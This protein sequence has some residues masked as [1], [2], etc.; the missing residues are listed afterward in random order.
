[1]ILWRGL[2]PWALRAWP[3]LAFVP[4]GLAHVIAIRAFPSDAAMVNKLV[5]MSLQVL[6]GLLVLYSVNDNLGIFR[7]QSL[8]SAIIA[9][10]KQFPLVRA[11]INLS[12]YGGATA[13][14]TA[15]MSATTQRSISTLEERIAELER[16]FKDLQ[17]Q[18]QREVEAVNARIE[19][20]RN[21]LQQ[22]I[23]D[24]SGR[25]TDLSRRLEHAAVGGFKFQALGVLLAVYGAV[26]SVFA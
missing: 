19:V 11:P 16:A 20:A 8:M 15:T 22:Q 12:G 25:V 17:Q 7:A 2:I 21:E 13:N 6:G 4:V 10:F 26:T 1:M 18:L 9:W 23:A 5:G 14:A 3:V 24:T